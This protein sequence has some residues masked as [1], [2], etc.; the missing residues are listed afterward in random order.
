MS[1]QRHGFGDGLHQAGSDGCRIGR[2]ADIFEY[3]NE[4]VS[5]G[6][7]DGIAFMNGMNQPACDLAQQGV[8][9]IVTEAFVDDTE[10]VDVE[11]EQGKHFAVFS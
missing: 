9:C 4:F 7:D 3:D 1:C 11:F 5:A 10:T 2:C 8:A 6:T